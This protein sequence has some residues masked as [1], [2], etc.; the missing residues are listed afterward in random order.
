[1]RVMGCDCSSKLIAAVIV[2]DSDEFKTHFMSSNSPDW[3]VRSRDLFTGFSELMTTLK[4]TKMMPDAIY[5]EQAVYVQNIKATLAI[6]S[7]INAV[8]FLAYM[9]GVYY[10]IV[11]NHSWKKA[12]L[13]NGKASKEQ[14]LEFSKVKW[15]NRISNQDIAD[16]SCIA[17]CGY[18]ILKGK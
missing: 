10:N 14:I 16:A 15:P 2:G 9:N 17:L 1:M 3:D 12:V 11:D 13:G 6:D 7:V 8:K 5:I 18:N 4:N